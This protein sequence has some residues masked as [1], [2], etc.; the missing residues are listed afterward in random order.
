M[1]QKECDKCGDLV[2]EAKAFC[3]GCGNAFVEEQKREERSGFEQ[4]DN[5]V[6]IGQSMYNQMLSDMGLNISKRR[7]PAERQTAKSPYISQRISKNREP[8]DKRVTV[9]A[10]V[11]ST[12]KLRTSAS[13]VDVEPKPKW[14]FPATMVILFIALCLLAAFIQIFLLWPQALDRSGFR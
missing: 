14:L 2:D 8:A 1:A 11:E 4:A 12:G 9:I 10:P 6:Q 7:D 5:T 13:K 3:P